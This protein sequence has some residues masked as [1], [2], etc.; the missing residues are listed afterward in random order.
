ME[1]LKP[2]W[3]VKAI[4]VMVYSTSVL[5]PCIYGA[6]LTVGGASGWNL[7]SNIQDWV[8]STTSFTV[9]DDL[10]FSY[11]V[12]HNVV[13]VNQKEYDTCTTTNAIAVYNNGD[14][15][16]PLTGPGARYFICAYH[17]QQG[18][19]LSVFVDFPKDEYSPYDTFD[20]IPGEG[21]ELGCLRNC[22]SDKSHGLWVSLITLILTFS[23]IYFSFL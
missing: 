3:A 11:T 13:E 4:M 14:T 12:D 15:V 6:N 10:V 17:C 8:A 21:E 19:K 16:I 9:K 2:V 7:G 1:R 23:S 5:F 20:F 18:L 22:V